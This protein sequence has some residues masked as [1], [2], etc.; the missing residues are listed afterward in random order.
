M[1]ICSRRREGAHPHPRRRVGHIHAYARGPACLLLCLLFGGPQICSSK[2]WPWSSRLEC[3]TSPIE[4]CSH[5]VLRIPKTGACS[6]SKGKCRMWQINFA[7]EKVLASGAKEH[8]GP[9]EATTL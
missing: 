2:P 7:G 6:Q 9:P 5:L 8:F 3:S 1:G 4:A